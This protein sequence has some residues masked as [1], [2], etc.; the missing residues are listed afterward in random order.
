M[1]CVYTRSDCWDRVTTDPCGRL[2]EASLDNDSTSQSVSTRTYVTFQSCCSS[3]LRDLK[4]DRSIYAASVG[5]LVGNTSIAE[6]QPNGAATL[7]TVT[8]R[9]DASMA[10]V[11]GQMGLTS[12][13][14]RIIGPTH[15]LLVDCLERE[16]A[17]GSPSI[18]WQMAVI[19]AVPGNGCL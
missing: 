19:D 16:V 9:N 1:A 18:G 14:H 3:V 5:S 4:P 8:L 11:V 2:L 13:H 17:I 6:R 10:R 7:P 12:V 15:P